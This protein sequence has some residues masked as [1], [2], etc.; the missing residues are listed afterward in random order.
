MNISLL[1]LIPL[2][3]ASDNHDI[4]LKNQLKDK[5]RALVTKEKD[6][7][8]RLQLH[9]EKWNKERKKTKEEQFSLTNQLNSTK[10]VVTGLGQELSSKKLYEE[11]RAQISSLQS[12]M[13]KVGEYKRALETKLRDKLDLIKGLQDRINLISLELKDKKK[14]TQP[15]IILLAEVTRTQTEL[16]SENSAV[17]ELNTRISTLEAEKK[18]YIQKLD[19]VS[20]DYSALQLTSEMQSAADAKIIRMKE[21]EIQQMK[22][23]LDHALNDVNE[24]KDKVAELTEKF[25]DSK[26]MLD[27]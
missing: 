10:E 20:K 27:I 15:I 24:S 4:Q 2:L 23:K 3:L 13:S 6:F 25:K 22:E 12:I 19:Y 1:D 8:V 14:K 21:E 9:Q 18:S 16:D 11:L 7:E 17:K 26:R 5:E